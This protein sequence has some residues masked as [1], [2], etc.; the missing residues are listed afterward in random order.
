MEKFKKIQILLQRNFLNFSILWKTKLIRT[1]GKL[2]DIFH[3]ESGAFL[4]SNALLESGALLESR[5]LLVSGR[6]RMNP[7]EDHKNS[8]RKTHI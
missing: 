6:V 4:E 2:R 1:A 5:I 8:L 3:I 7:A